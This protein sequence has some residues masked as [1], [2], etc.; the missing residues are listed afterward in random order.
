MVIFKSKIYNELKT[1]NDI[2][3]AKIQLPVKG[4]RE[5][6]RIAVIDDKR[7]F[8]RDD[9]IKTGFVNVTIN[10][11]FENPKQYESF[12]IILCDIDGVSIEKT[13]KR[14]GIAVAKTLK[15]VYPQKL[16]ILYSG[17]RPEEFDPMYYKY[18]DDYYNKSLSS[19][20]L[21]DRIAEKCNILWDPREAWLWTRKQLLENEQSTKSIAWLEDAYVRS[22]FERKNYLDGSF[23]KRIEIAINSVALLVSIIKIFIP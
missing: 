14:Q 23:L 11:T 17:N 5:K 3:N 10:D 15:Q 2:S 19:G 22:F 9:F 6:V 16:I 13:D 7:D 21:A 12:D 20:E 18:V 1:I 4:D 8:F